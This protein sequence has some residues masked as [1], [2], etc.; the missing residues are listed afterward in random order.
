MG[1]LRGAALLVRRYQMLSL[2]VGL[3][4]AGSLMS[5]YFLT[6]GNLTNIAKQVSVIGISAVGGTFVII[7]AGIDL[8]VGPMIA[9]VSVSIALM[10]NLPPW[11]AFAVALVI[12]LLFGLTN[13]TLVSYGRVP[14]FIATIGMGGIASGLALAWSGGWPLFI[15][16][17]SF[18]FVGQ[19]QIAGVPISPV[20]FLAVAVFGHVL[21]TRTPFGVYVFALGNNEEALRLAAVSTKRTRTLLFGLAGFLAALSGIAACSRS[22]TGDPSIGSQL[23]FD[24]ICAIVVGGTRIEG[25]AGGI[26]EAVIGTIMIGVLNNVMNLMGVNIY[27]QLLFKGAIIIVA[28][29]TARSD[30]TRVLSTLWRPRATGADSQ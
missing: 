8:S 30:L 20:L 6:L 26:V 25:G 21:L 4:A 15:T 14:A 5:S 22:M 7:S 17:R 18:S 1:L 28:V 24:V 12:G 9:L 2:M 3:I 16:S 23:S 27:Y 19:G 13:G 10:Q 29:L 11:L